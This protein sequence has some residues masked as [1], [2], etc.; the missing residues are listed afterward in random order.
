MVKMNAYS[1]KADAKY[2]SRVWFVFVYNVFIHKISGIWHIYMYIY[3]YICPTGTAKV[4]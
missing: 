2:Y 3:V 1:K 4:L